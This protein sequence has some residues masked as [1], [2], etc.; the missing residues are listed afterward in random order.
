LARLSDL[1]DHVERHGFL[2]ARFVHIAQLLGGLL[3]RHAPDEI[4]ERREP[5]LADRYG[6][7]RVHDAARQGLRTLG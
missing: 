7:I 3:G 6:A 2:S 1:D 5:R 4:P